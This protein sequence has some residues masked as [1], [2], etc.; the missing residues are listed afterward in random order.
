MWDISSI[1]QRLKPD[2][3]MVLIQIAY[4]VMTIIYKLAIN[5]GMSM[6]VAA[7][8]RLICASAFT[9]LVAL[10]FDRKNR[11]K[12]TWSV[13]FKS[14]LC[15]LFGGSLFLNLYL[16]GLALTS[17]TFMLVVINLIPA[18]TF[19]MAVCFRMDKFNLR[20]AEGKAKVI[21]TIMGIGGAMLMIFFKGAEIHIWSSN[22]NL[23][24]P[25]HN[26]NKQMATH[27]A[28]FGKKLLGVSC[29]LASSCSFSLWYIIQAKLNKEYSSH[30]SSAA[31]MSTMG[32]IQGTIIALCFERDWEQWKLQNNL[33][34]LAVIYP[35]IVASGLVVIAM[36]WCIKMRGPVF[37]SIF[38][39]LQ[40]L[41]VVIAAYFMLDEK[42]YLGSMLGAIVIVCG[43]Y[44]VLWGQSKELKK[45]KM[46]LEI[47]RMPENDELVVISTPAISHDKVVQT[48]TS[49]AITKDNVV[50]E[51]LP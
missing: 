24:H 7:A 1:W 38:S 49:S 33:R 18:I 10:I 23:L 30:R 41:L 16:V 47:T 46:I 12:I 13:L 25:H 4:A 17:A 32:A 5:D 37:A 29:A 43:L 11:A 2:V 50:N 51:Q 6:R 31:L 44:A 48:Y 42:L 26:Q 15:G 21:G 39:P 22:T 20:V 3:V 36:A 27:H 9:V 14:F 28:D 40:L 19:I 45:K 8:Y 35:G 34:I